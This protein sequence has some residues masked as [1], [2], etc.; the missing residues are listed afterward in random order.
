MLD[1]AVRAASW[2]ILAPFAVATP[3]LA[4]LAVWD[5][6]DV[7]S[8]QILALGSVVVAVELFWLGGR[9]AGMGAL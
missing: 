8:R 3:W 7:P 6:P 5:A 9:L 4:V 1:A 2:L